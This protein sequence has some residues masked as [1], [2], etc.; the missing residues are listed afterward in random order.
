M[1]LRLFNIEI[2][3]SL[4]I[5]LLF[6]VSAN[7]FSACSR[8][9]ANKLCVVLLTEKHGSREARRGRT[10]FNKFCNIKKIHES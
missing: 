4:H 9:A 3:L 7:F 5:F 6:L 1:L 10:G 8:R 2:L